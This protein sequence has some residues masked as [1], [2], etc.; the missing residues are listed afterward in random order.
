MQTLAF[1]FICQ[2]EDI[3]YVGRKT[4]IET[5]VLWRQGGQQLGTPA[6]GQVPDFDLSLLN[7]DLIVR[8]GV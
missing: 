3:V 1:G 7:M 8:A 4:H 2:D 6:N 5:S